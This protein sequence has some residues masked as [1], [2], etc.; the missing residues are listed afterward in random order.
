[1]ESGDGTRAIQVWSGSD[2]VRCTRENET[3]WLKAESTGYDVFVPN[4]FQFLR[5]WYDT[6]EL[7]ALEQDIVIPNQGQSQQEIAQAWAD[8]YTQRYLDVT[9][10][11][12]YAYTYVRNVVKIWEAPLEEWFTEEMLKTEHFYFSY[13]CIFVP[14]NEY[15]LNWSMAGNTGTYDGQYG[16]APESAYVYHLMGP[17]YLSK[18][19]WRCGG[20]GSGP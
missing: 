18:D 12:R 17:M 4:I 7:K 19:G 15:S 5:F 1:M 9:P 10:G 11:S 14:D 6:V 16:Q 13:A 3:F 8:Q 20:V 2:L